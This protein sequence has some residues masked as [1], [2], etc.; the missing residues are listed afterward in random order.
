MIKQT[1]GGHNVRNL[2]RVDKI[3]LKGGVSSRWNPESWEKV[4]FKQ[5]K[6]NPTYYACNL[7][8]WWD[9]KLND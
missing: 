4:I 9:I 6:R 2:Y 1:I 7:G 8:E 3:T 5:C